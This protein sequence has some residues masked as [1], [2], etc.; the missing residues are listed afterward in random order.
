MG[1]LDD[2]VGHS[3]QQCEQLSLAVKRHGSRRVVW[4]VIDVDGHVLLQ[5]TVLIFEGEGLLTNKLL[6]QQAG[7]SRGNLQAQLHLAI[8][9]LVASVC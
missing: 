2:A 6:H 5:V 3:R 7:L 1:P 8:Y 4:V 9:H